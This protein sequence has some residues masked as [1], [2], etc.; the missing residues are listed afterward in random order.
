MNP[1]E[2]ADRV[3]DGLVADGLVAEADR[4][5]A[6]AA[7]L[8]G[9]KAPDSNAGLPKLVE[10]IAYLGAALVLAAGGLFLAETWEDL[11][12]AGQVG[13]LAVVALVLAVAGMVARPDRTPSASRIRLASTLLTGAAVLAG[14]AVGLALEYAGT[15]SDRAYDDVYWPATIG[16]AT[17]LLLSIGCYRL[18]SSAIGQLGILGGAFVIVTTVAPSWDG[19]ES[20]N[21]GSTLAALALVW[22]V[23]AE[24]GAFAQRSAARAFGLVLALFGAQLVS[25]ASSHESV[26]YALMVVLVA[27]SVALYLSRLDSAYLATAVIGLTLVVPEAVSDWTDGSLGVIGGVLVAGVTLLVASF[28][29]YRLRAEATD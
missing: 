13:A 1:D 23:A 18:A 9:L 20:L 7:V 25:L 6:R 12:E 11:G 22:L 27:G 26:G 28:T 29:G 15:E 14:C 10:V 21:V 24:V 16:A 17:T 19:D 2:S 5:R 4:A 8:A 3:V